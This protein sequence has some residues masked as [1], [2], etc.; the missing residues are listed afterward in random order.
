MSG[1]EKSLN[2]TRAEC[3]HLRAELDKVTQ[4]RQQLDKKHQQITQKLQKLQSE[5]E[6]EKQMGALMRA[7]KQALTAE[8]DELR[9]QKEVE[10]ADLRDQLHDLMMHF[11]AQAKI[12][13]QAEKGDITQE[14]L[15]ESHVEVQGQ[16]SST[17]S[18]GVK[19]KRRKAK[20]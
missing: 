16:D 7:D 11:E 4:S 18:G 17:G 20:K 9:Q 6:E 13:E 15:T 2:E 19:G 8:R 14:E 5:L 10:V 1:L 12:Q 3:S